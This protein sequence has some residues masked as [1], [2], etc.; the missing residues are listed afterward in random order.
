MS[1]NLTLTIKDRNCTAYLLANGFTCKFVPRE[2]GSTL[3][4]EFVWSEDLDRARQDY[5]GNRGI[6][7]QS[8]IAACR[9]IGDLIKQHNQRRGRL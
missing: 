1:N 4:A 7:V 5:A 2:D 6:P 8:F 3:D 9:H